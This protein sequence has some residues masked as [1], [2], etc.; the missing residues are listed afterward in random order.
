MKIKRA[1][2]SSEHKRYWKRERERE[3][4]LEKGAKVKGQS[5][6]GRE[7]EKESERA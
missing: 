6:R 3:S 5:E 4:K 7:G 1:R 2:E